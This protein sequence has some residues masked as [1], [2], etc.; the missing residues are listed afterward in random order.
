MY[1]GNIDTHGPIDGAGIV[2]VS[3]DRWNFGDHFDGEIHGFG[4]GT[5]GDSAV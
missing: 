5:D 3:N 1:Q 4:F 2:V